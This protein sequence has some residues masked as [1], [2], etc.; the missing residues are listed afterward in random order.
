MK[1]LRFLVTTA[2]QLANCRRRIS[3]RLKLVTVYGLVPFIFSS[4]FEVVDK[5]LSPVADDFVADL[6]NREIEF[7]LRLRSLRLEVVADIASM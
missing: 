5:K 7:D 3:P 2:L 1:F 6:D 4:R